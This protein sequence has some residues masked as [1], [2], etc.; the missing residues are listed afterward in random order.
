MPRPEQAFV[1]LA[2]PASYVACDW[3]LCAD[4]AGCDYWVG[5]FKRHVNTIL[6]LGVKCSNAGADAAERAAAC[7][8]EFYATFDRFHAD[9]SAHERVTIL[10]LDEW[11]DGLLQK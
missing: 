2:D 10:T 7:R 8:E 5:L 3:N 11:R 9:P 1:K 6:D 4:R